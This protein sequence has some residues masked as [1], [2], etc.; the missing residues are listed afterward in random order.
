MHVICGEVQEEIAGQLTCGYGLALCEGG[1]WQECIINNT[2]T[3]EETNKNRSLGP[4]TGLSTDGEEH[5]TELGYNAG[6]RQ[7]EKKT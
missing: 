2:V 4:P 7:Q 6:V 1:E 3:V 5:L